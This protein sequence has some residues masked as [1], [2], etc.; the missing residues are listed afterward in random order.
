MTPQVEG[1]IGTSLRTLPNNNGLS[2]V[3]LVG[4]EPTRYDTVEMQPRYPTDVYSTIGIPL[5]RILLH[6]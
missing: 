2:N 5:A 1:Q 3:K 4:Y 6:W